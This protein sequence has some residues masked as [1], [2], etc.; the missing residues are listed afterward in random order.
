M[1][2]AAPERVRPDTDSSASGL[3][4]SESGRR[5]LNPRPPEP[6]SGA[7]PGCATSRQCCNVT[8]TAPF[9]NAGM[10]PVCM[11]LRVYARSEACR[12]TVS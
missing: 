5:D 2:S 6:H 12:S 4:F 7:L 10:K 9:L 3:S 8:T 11:K 1:T